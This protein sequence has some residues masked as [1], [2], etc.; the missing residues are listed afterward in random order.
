MKVFMQP[1]HHKYE[2]FGIQFLSFDTPHRYWWCRLHRFKSYISYAYILVRP[3]G[4]LEGIKHFKRDVLKTVSVKWLMLVL[5][6]LLYQSVHSS[7]VSGWSEMGS[8]GP[9]I[10]AESNASHMI[11]TSNHFALIITKVVKGASVSVPWSPVFFS[12]LKYGTES[13]GGILIK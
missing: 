9:E 12:F 5:L 3:L 4:A 8:H 1:G 10:A 2:T 6:L 11:R 13:H 7:D